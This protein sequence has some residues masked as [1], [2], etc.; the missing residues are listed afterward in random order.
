L[1]ANPWACGPDRLKALPELAEVEFGLT[2]R[3]QVEGPIWPA[4]SWWWFME[5]DHVRFVRRHYP[6]AADRTATIRRLCEDLPPAPPSLAERVAGLG[7]ADA[8]LFRCGRRPRPCRRR[9]AGVR[10][11]CDRAVAL[12]RRLITLFV[13]A[14]HLV[15]ELTLLWT[16]DLARTAHFRKGSDRRHHR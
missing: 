7:L 4:P 11:L 15:W 10:G 2:A 9:G 16:G 12:C 13:A 1:T 3:R 6:E 5:A 14:D 8:M